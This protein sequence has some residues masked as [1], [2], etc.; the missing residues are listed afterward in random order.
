MIYFTIVLYIFGLWRPFL[1]EQKGFILTNVRVSLPSKQH[2]AEPSQFSSI[3][4]RKL[5]KGNFYTGAGN[6]NLLNVEISLGKR[7]HLCLIR[8]HA[9]NSYKT[10]AV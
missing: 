1:R 8:Y 10:Q 3:D 5:M 9:K 4:V 2:P 6:L 7:L